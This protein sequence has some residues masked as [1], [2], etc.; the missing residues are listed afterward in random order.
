[1]LEQLNSPNSS[2]VPLLRLAFRPFFLFGAMYSAF[3]IAIWVLVFRG[4]LTLDL[5]GGAVFW[6]THEMLFGFIAAIVVGFLL[7]AVQNWTGIKSVSGFPLFVLLILW[8]T[9]R[10]G[11]LLGDTFSGFLLAVIDI[12]FLLIATIFLAVPLIKVKQTR[13]LFFVPLLLVFAFINGM[14]HVAH[15]NHSHSLVIQ[16]TQSGLM[17]IALLIV[18]IGGR[19]IPFFTAN[20]TQTQRVA[21]IIWLERLALGNCWLLFLGFL[22]GMVYRL[23]KEVVAILFVS[24]AIL[25]LVRWWRWRF[26]I[27]LNVSLLWT[28]HLAY[29]FV[30]VSFLFLALSWAFNFI[31][32]SIGWHMLTVGGMGAMIL[33]MISRVSLGHT[34]RAIV[35]PK[36][37]FPAF[38]IIFIAAF[39]RTMAVVLLPQ[40]YLTLI[41][42]SGLLWVLAFLIFV[43]GYFLVLTKAR[44]DGKPG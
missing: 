44:V 6:H 3:A 21:A 28:L 43:L 15:I 24:A 42:I 41:S 27:T 7:T 17:L 9:A 8:L 11:F 29:L 1:M 32:A 4:Q 34:G 20:G 16:A 37:M 13:N 33:S 2:K 10:I 18:V 5:Y 19:V 30:L 14:M 40:H 38:V 25:N 39:L 22:S 26:W 23:P 12:S 36:W 31:A 35:G